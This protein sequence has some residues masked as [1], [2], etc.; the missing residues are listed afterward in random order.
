M[1]EGEVAN[2]LASL[3]NLPKSPIYVDA[4][5]AILTKIL[6]L[7]QKQIEDLQEQLDEHEEDYEHVQKPCPD[8]FL[9]VFRDFLRLDKE[10]EAK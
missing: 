8:E 9:E 7:Q 3:D 1:S 2:L 10:K 6:E 4:K 5:I